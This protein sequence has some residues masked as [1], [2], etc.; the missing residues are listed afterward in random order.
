VTLFPYTTLFRSKTIGIEIDDDFRPK[1]IVMPERKKLISEIKL[2]TEDADAVYLATDPDREGEAISWHLIE[3]AKLNLSH[4]PLHRVVFHEITED[5]VKKAFKSP[6]D[7]DMDLV[8]AQQARRLLDR[9]VGYKLSPFLWKKVLRGLSAG[10]VQSAAVRIVVDRERE[11]LAFKPVEYWAIEVELKKENS[12]TVKNNFKATLVS[13][14]GGGKITISNGTD[15]KYICD[16]LEKSD[17]SV[18]SVLTKPSKKQPAPPF[19]TSTMQQEAFRKFHFTAKRTMV[20]AQQLYEGIAIGEEG[21]V[22]LITYMRTDSTHLAPGAVSETRDYIRAKF[23]EDYI[24]EKPRVFTKKG[25]FTQEAHEAIRPTKTAREPELI[26]HYLK[27]EQYKLYQLI[28]KRMVACQMSEARYQITTI[29]ILAEN[30][31]M[32][33]G[34]FLKTSNTKLEFPGFTALYSEGKDEEEKEENGY[35]P[36]VK[37]GETL[38]FVELFPKQN[39]TEPPPRYNE[40]TLIKAL[41]QKGI[42]RPSTYAPIISTIQDREY[43][44]KDG[45]RFKPGEM[46]FIVNDILVKNFPNIVDL[47][48]TAEVEGDLD[49]I[50]SGK[51]DWVSLLRDFYKPFEDALEKAS[52]NVEK[53]KTDVMT[54]QVCPECGKPMVI[55]RGRFGKFMACSG[56]PECKK[57]M[58]IVSTTGIPCPKCG[59]TEHGELVQ[60]RSKKGKIFYGCKRYPNCDFV[61]WNKPVKQPCPNC[62]N[63]MTETRKGLVKCTGCNY[64]GE[65]ENLEKAQAS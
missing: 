54:D 13:L 28:W 46:G 4:K 33:A 8:N 5:A 30:K 44:I 6:R 55:K 29:E 35:I 51:K 50:A 23:G 59:S 15:S 7:L 61:V 53:V 25:K 60:R 1:Y 41:E 14:A 16:V 58:P 43:V 34:Y 17:Y 37:K 9:L 32:N 65:A 11:I 42:G 24:P 3:A 39:F 64:E 63:L 12:K 19:I 36:D 21:T 57:T 27:P 2:A 20:I 31:K 52:T 18:S 62:G 45:G 48:F 26:Q 40:A 10:R 47:N 22:G 56:Y 49:K 38:D